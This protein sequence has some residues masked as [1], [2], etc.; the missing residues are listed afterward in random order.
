M[1]TPD[2]TATEAAQRRAEAIREGLVSKAKLLTE[3][4][5]HACN[6]KDLVVVAGLFQEGADLLSDY[7]QGSVHVTHTPTTTRKVRP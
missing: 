6:R 7:S 4:L 5:V 3:K 1:S 2:P